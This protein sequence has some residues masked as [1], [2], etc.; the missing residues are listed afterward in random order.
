MSHPRFHSGVRVLRAALLAL[1]LGGLVGCA[2]LLPNERS[3]SLFATPTTGSMHETAL[4]PSGPGTVF[5]SPQAA[6]LD[7]LAWCYLQ[8]RERVVSARR[9]R[10]GTIRA[11]AGGFSYDE[12]A[13]ANASG[14]GVLRY[15]MGTGDVAHFRHYPVARHARSG[16]DLA[17]R[18]ARRFVERV[19]PAQRPFF[20]LTPERRVRVYEASAAGG[21]TLA[22]VRFG[23]PRGATSLAM[24]MPEMDPSTSGQPLALGTPR[25]PR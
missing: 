7:A 14:A 3:S 2:G 16:W 6:A 23:T 18:E 20:Y 13:V 21:E 17:E 11:V 8:S 10:G 12:P 4:E 25:P 22:R 15:A 9:V 24:Q 19:D 1:V 5:E